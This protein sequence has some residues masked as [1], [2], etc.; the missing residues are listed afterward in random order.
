MSKNNIDINKTSKEDW[1][2]SSSNRDIY[3]FY[4]NNG[5]GQQITQ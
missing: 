2:R 1:W 4:I 3:D 5:F